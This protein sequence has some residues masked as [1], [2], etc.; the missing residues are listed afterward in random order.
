[1][2]TRKQTRKAE[3]LAFESRTENRCHRQRKGHARVIKIHVQNSP[4]LTESSPFGPQSLFSRL[5]REREFLQQEISRGRNLL[6]QWN[7]GPVSNGKL[8]AK[9][10][11]T[12]DADKPLL[13]ADQAMQKFL[14]GWV[15]R[16]EETLN[17]VTC[18]IAIESARQPVVE[19]DESMFQLL[20]SA[21]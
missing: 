12:A 17:S 6:G 11:W 1:M 10:S 19:A 18:Q 14:A 3:D 8:E 2:K 16:L 4:S 20:R 9:T 21:H 7:V 13:L 5:L 15:A